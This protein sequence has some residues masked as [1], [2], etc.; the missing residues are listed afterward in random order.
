MLKKQEAIVLK[1]IDYGETNKIV[2]L[3]T[4]DQGKIAVLAKGAKKT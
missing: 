4:R 2:T 3:F 1:T